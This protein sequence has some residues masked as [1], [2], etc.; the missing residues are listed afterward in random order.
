M[1]NFLNLH[2]FDQITGVQKII[3]DI[4]WLASYKFKYNA[5]SLKFYSVFNA[6]LSAKTS[7]PIVFWFFQGQN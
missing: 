6:D 1:D 5:L 3:F 2:F 4:Y 7:C